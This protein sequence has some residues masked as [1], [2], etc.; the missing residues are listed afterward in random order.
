MT[1]YYQ[2][3]CV[4]TQIIHSIQNTLFLEQIRQNYERLPLNIE[5]EDIQLFKH[6]GYFLQT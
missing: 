4:L 3:A 2:T 5:K 6:D 1:H